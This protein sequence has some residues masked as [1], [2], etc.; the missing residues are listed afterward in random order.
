[1]A[2]RF[3]TSVRGSLVSMIYTK[4]TDLSI[5]ALNES[6]AVT[7]MSS[8]VETI[9]Q[10]LANVHEIWAVPIE[11]VIALYLLD[12]QLGVAFFAPALVAAISTISILLL[13]KYIGNAQ[14][15]W[16]EGIQTRV[17]VTATML[18]SMKVSVSH[19]TGDRTKAC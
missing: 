9:C 7:L 18:G 4:T 8:D 15:I 2:Y 11:L 16:I 14:K 10:G 1:M 12:R 6:A 17:D 3:V 13:A 19:V 5:T